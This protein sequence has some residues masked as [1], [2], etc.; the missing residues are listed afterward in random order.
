[1]RQE[2]GRES[3]AG[4]PA[5]SQGFSFAPWTKLPPPQAAVRLPASSRA[6]SV[7]LW[8]RLAALV[9]LIIAS[10]LMLLLT[11]AIKLEPPAGGV[12]Y[13]QERVGLERRRRPG[14][15]ASAEPAERRRTPGHGQVFLIYKFR[16]MV[17]EAEKHTGPVWASARDP[18][19]TRVGRVLRKLRF[20]ELPQ[21][22][23]VL[24]G[25]MRLIGPRPERPRFVE[26]LRGQIPDYTQRLSVHP[27]ITGLAQ[28]ERDYDGSVEDVRKKVQYDLF[29]V[30]HRSRLL[31]IKIILKTISVMIL[32]RGAR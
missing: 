27:G 17:P 31:D 21:L 2:S 13:R 24:Q 8:E 19:I 3:P 30:R 32:G 28:V 5:A 1:R 4:P 14:G 26:Q 29:Y 12:F 25:Q 9:L 15:A 16:T 6:G 10:P 22:I 11:L 7:G 20:D 23:N 18:R